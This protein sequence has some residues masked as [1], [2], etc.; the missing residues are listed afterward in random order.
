MEAEKPLH[1]VILDAGPIIKNEPPIS[2]LLSK[3]HKIIT[4]PAIINEIRDTATRARLQ[5]TLLPFLELRDPSPAS[6]KIISDFARRTGDLQVLSKPDIQLLALTYEVECEKNGGDWRL[7]SLPGQKKLNGSPP[8]RQTETPQTPAVDAQLVDDQSQETAPCAAADQYGLNLE[9]SHDETATQQSQA[10]PS[11]SIVT[12]MHNSHIS[13]PA[14]TSSL[15]QTSTHPD[16]RPETQTTTPPNISASPDPDHNSDSDADSEGWITPSN[17]HSHQHASGTPSSSS[18]NAL[19]PHTL[20]AACLTSDFAMQNVLL[21]M[22]LNLISPTLTRVRHIKTYVLRCHA[23][24]LVVRDT[25]KQFCPR[26][27]KPSL[28]RVACSTDE[29]GR[30]SLHLKRNMQWN[31][32]G[33]RYAVPKPIAGTANGKIKAGQGG[34]KGGWGQGLILAEDQKEYVRAVGEQRRVKERNLMD[35]DYLP[36]ILTGERRSAGAKIVVGAGRNVNSRKR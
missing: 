23:C 14:P 3:S 1:T 8:T 19:A 36:A 9:E 17:L 10:D 6:I 13:S 21:Q 32:R 20:Q 27:G 35:E 4:V 12:D 5:T 18:P 30:F 26:C 11:E 31:T 24:F 34:G 29:Q 16:P 2:T 28:T 25:S 22:N 15:P 33:D 7:R